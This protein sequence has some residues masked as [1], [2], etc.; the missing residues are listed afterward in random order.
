[1]NT[2]TLKLITQY[3][4]GVHL[5]IYLQDLCAEKYTMLTKKMNEDLNK[6]RNILCSWTGMLK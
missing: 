4:V 2:K 5:K 1:M 6:R 3:L